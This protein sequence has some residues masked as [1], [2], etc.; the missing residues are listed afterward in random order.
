MSGTGGKLGWS[1]IFVCPV[2]ILR[3]KVILSLCSTADFGRLCDNSSWNRCCFQYVYSA[4]SF[5]RS[6]AL[7]FGVIALV[8]FPITAKFLT[9]EERAYVIYKKSRDF[10]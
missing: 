6:L 10:F 4:K 2:T 8:D 3:V 5:R 7:I 9:P 1:W